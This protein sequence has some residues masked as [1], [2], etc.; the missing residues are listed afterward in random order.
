MIGLWSVPPGFASTSVDALMAK[1]V[2]KGILTDKEVR[3]L[4]EEIASDEKLI[5]EEGY[6][7]GLPAW[8]QNTNIKGDFRLRHEYSK[9]N[10]SSDQDR[11]RGRIRYRLGFETKIN[12]Q[13]RV[14][15][16]LASNGGNPRST[17]QTF[18]DAFAKSAIN[19]DYAYAEFKPY[20][21]LALTGGKMKIPFWEAGDLL[22]DTDITPEGGAINLNMNTLPNLMTFFNMGV[23][24]LDESAADQTDPYFFVFEPGVQLKTSDEKADLKLA[25]AYYSFSHGAPKSML[26]NRSSPTTNS[27]TGGRY[28]FKYDSFNPNV[29]FGI[30]NLFESFHLPI[31]IPRIAVFGEYVNNPAP[32]DNNTGWLAGAY[33]GDKKVSGPGQWQVKGSYRSL[34]KDAW[35]DAFPDSD[36]Y[37][38][39]TDV[40]GYETIFEYGL[41]K[42]ASIA[43]DYYRTQRIKAEKAVETVLQTDFNFKF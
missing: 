6:K 14:A 32:N 24:I 20:S 33:M 8:I 25:L 37:G 43:L 11:S 28:D 23:F 31:P 12:D 15:A 29:E 9:R 30:N 13:T 18:T 5:R 7:Q 26:D 27:V 10:D 35:L 40:K 41:N 21:W 38:G 4:K 42:N 16:G 3:D 17:N 19:L 36:F 34:G 2:E 1:L 39:A 22:W